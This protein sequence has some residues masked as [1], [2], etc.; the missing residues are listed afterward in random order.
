[1]D[2]KICPECGATVESI[3]EACPKCGCAHPEYITHLAAGEVVYACGQCR[4]A[5]YMRRE[6]NPAVTCNQFARSIKGVALHLPLTIWNTIFR[7]VG[8]RGWN[9]V[10][11]DERIN[12]FEMPCPECGVP[13]R[14]ETLGRHLAVSRE[15]LQPLVLGEVRRAGRHLTLKCGHHI[16]LPTVIGERDL[17]A[18]AN[19]PA[20]LE[21]VVASRS[22]LSIAAGA[23]AAVPPAAPQSE[24]KKTQPIPLPVHGR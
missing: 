19:Q 21:P 12:G 16:Y 13:T 6:E 15:F 9:W 3:I 1:M 20:P 22:P 10:A 17:R 14:V 8:C 23:G 18:A 24:K 11:L 7:C 2:L 4:R 5:R